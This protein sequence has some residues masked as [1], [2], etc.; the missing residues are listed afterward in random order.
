LLP[1]QLTVIAPWLYSMTALLLSAMAGLRLDEQHQ[2][3]KD[4]CILIA[5][6]VEQ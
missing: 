3:Q 4:T 5:Q 6:L 2:Y 1:Q